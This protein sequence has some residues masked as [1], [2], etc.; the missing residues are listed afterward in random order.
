MTGPAAD[1]PAPTGA[2]DRVVEFATRRIT[3]D[4]T[5]DE[6]GFD[7][8]LTEK[9]LLPAIRPLYDSYFRADWIGLD[10]VPD[11]GPGLIVG[12]HAGTVPLDAMVLRFGL[13]DKLPS[14]R[15]LRLL[16]AD[17]V[18]RLPFVG[19]VSRRS[20][21]TLACREDALRLLRA[22]ELVGVFPEGFKGTGK[23]YRD[24]YRLQRFGRGGFVRVAMSARAPIVPVAIVGSEEAYPMVHDSRLL[25][26]GL[27]LPY[28]PITPLFPWLGPLGAVPLPARWIVEFAE[29]VPTDEYPADAWRDPEVVFDL[30][31]RVRQTIQG[32]LDRNLARRRS[33]SR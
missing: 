31:D 25:A 12:N 18:F 9:V 19:A 14:H 15:H 3:G 24:R 27:G 30:T 7:R 29:P 33:S 8:E 21:A 13:L 11:A 6:F 23:L 20:G 22:G 5:V 16:G 2:L 17:L 32:V 1:R 28:F 4:F 26:R 10:N